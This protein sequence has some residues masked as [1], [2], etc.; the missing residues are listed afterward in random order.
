MLAAPVE[1]HG[2]ACQHAGTWRAVGEED[3]RRSTT[4][5]TLGGDA[6]ALP[7]YKTPAE[8]SWMQG[9]KGQMLEGGAEGGT[10]GDW[11]PAPLSRR[12]ACSRHTRI[13]FKAHRDRGTTAA[14]ARRLQMIAKTPRARVYTRVS[15]AVVGRGLARG[16][17][18]HRVAQKQERLN[19]A[20]S[21]FQAIARPRWPGLKKRSWCAA[22]RGAQHLR[23]WAAIIYLR[24]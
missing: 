9:M 10:K 3:E 17:R 7:T 1:T 15:W 4:E 14:T 18:L 8:L 24:K 23:Q 20:L 12:A 2:W 11:Q 21:P 5:G 22:A 16:E 6:V 13:T 19:E